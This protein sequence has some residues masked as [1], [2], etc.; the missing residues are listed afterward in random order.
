MKG[1][2]FSMPLTF[3]LFF[4]GYL[5]CRAFKYLRIPGG[6][7]TGFLALVHHLAVGA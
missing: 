5:E 4:L 6:V 3:V 7:M 2:A 1:I